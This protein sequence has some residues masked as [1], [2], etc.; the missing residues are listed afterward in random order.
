MN[1]A[2]IGYGNVGRA[3]AR[4]LERKRASFPFRICGI[5][6]AR[7]GTA[8]DPKGLRG[9][10]RFGPAIQLFYTQLADVAEGLTESQKNL[11]LGDKL[12][13]MRQTM[14]VQ[15]GKSR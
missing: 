4:L 15:Q 6:T 10:P 7:H 3:F 8:L 11:W 1:L 12:T 5:H 13:S 9:D 14:A 2:L